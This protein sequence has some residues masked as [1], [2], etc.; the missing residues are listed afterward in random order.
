M[1]NRLDHKP[2]LEV[3]RPERFLLLDVLSD[4]RHDLTEAVQVHYSDLQAL[5]CLCLLQQCK[6][7][8]TY[9]DVL[10]T[11]TSGFLLLYLLN[12]GCLD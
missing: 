3:L 10:V 9:L 8:L 1:P 11:E 12:H 5:E 4:C 7:V 2:E 6:Y